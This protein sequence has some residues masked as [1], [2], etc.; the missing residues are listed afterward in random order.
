M[1]SASRRRSA[2]RSPPENNMAA[3]IAEASPGLWGPLSS[4]AS[5]RAT[6]VRGAGSTTRSPMA[7]IAASFERPRKNTA[8]PGCSATSPRQSARLSTNPGAGHPSGSRRAWTTPPSRRAS[9]TMQASAIPAALHS[10]SATT[11]GPPPPP[12]CGLEVRLGQGRHRRVQEGGHRR[13]DPPDRKDPAHH[14]GILG[15]AGEHVFIGLCGAPGDPPE[16]C[17]SFNSEHL[18]RSCPME[19]V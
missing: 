10:E 13:S 4:S 17:F 16:R 6:Q 19:F 12:S 3:V 11:P 7:A 15:E 18:D 5:P 8:E 9:T 2:A 1:R 14:R